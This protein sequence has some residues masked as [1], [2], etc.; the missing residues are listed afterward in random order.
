[1][2]ELGVAIPFYSGLAYL[3]R[4][5][6]SLL[7]QSTE[8]WRAIV[9]D[10]AGPDS[11]AR[12]VVREFADSRICYVRNE[13]NLGLARNWNLCLELVDAELVTLL[14][15]DDELS[16]NYV[17]TVLDAHLRHPEAAAVHTRA[18]VIGSRSTPIFSFPDV[19]KEFIAPRG[20]GAQITTGD[21]GLATVLQ[22]QFIFCPALSYKTRLLPDVPFDEAWRQVLDLDL[23]ARLL[24]DGQEIVGVPARA[25]RYRRHRASQTTLLTSSRERFREEFALYS[26]IAQRAAAMHW[27]RSAVVAR[28]A[29]IV[30]AHVFY[31]ALGCALRGH[32]QETRSTVALLG[33]RR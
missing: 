23:I 17:Q 8:R 25:Y 1:M 14:H 27:E 33:A 6:Q 30:R 13:S 10:D 26:A 32:V 3:R 7:G 20:R 9:V 24:F 2:S 21:A 19:V 5:I 18:I 15:A 12:D 28:R 4:A 22:G 16:D 11:E 29:R 31:R